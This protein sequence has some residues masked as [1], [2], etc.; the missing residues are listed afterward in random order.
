[1]GFRPGQGEC[2]G[3]RVAFA[4]V[5]EGVYMVGRPNRGVPPEHGSGGG[6]RGWC[7]TPAGRTASRAGEI[8][9][10][11]CRPGQGDRGGDWVAVA[12]VRLGAS[13]LTTAAIMAAGLVKN[14]K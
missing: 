3:K 7:A 4:K 1:M 8:A 14:K 10:K 13:L 12:K 6:T 11:G 9:Q 5:R 2:R